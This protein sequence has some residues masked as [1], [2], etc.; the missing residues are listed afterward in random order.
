MGTSP[1]FYLTMI[2]FD[3]LRVTNDGEYLIID[4]RVRKEKV[5]KD[6][7]IKSVLIG[8]HKNYVER[9][10]TGLTVDITN[11]YVNESDDFDKRVFLRLS[12]LDINMNAS[13]GNEVDL[14][15]DLIYVYIE[16]SDDVALENCPML[17]CDMTQTLNIGVTMYM[18]NI[19]N[20]FMN[21]IKEIENAGS[22]CHNKTPQNLIDFILKYITLVTAVD[23]KHFIK[24][25]ELFEKWFSGGV[26]SSNNSNCGCNG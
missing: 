9:T 25:N 17:P 2:I 16:T 23:S 12:S 14:K 26:F 24:A 13:E 11:E 10:A 20:T 1:L 18:G 5:Y 21:N 15:K 22:S 19:Y 4:A 7:K 8:T 3:E 6:V